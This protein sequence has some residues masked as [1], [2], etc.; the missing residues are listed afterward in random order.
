MDS[1]NALKCCLDPSIHSAQSAALESLFT[2]TPGF[3]HED[4][5]MFFH[6]VPDCEDFVFEPHRDVHNLA[7]SM[8]VESGQAPARTIDFKRKHITDNML[9]GWANQAR[10]SQYIGNHF[11]HPR[12]M[13]KCS[14]HLRAKC[15]DPSHIKGGTWL[16]DIGNSSSLTAQMVRGLTSHAPIGHY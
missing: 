15:M 11:Q 8:K 13:V 10:L 6:H 9:N 3:E 2:L 14:N 5:K 1:T 7:T 16:K 12:W 4:T